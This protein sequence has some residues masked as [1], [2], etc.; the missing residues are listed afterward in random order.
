M[1]LGNVAAK[2]DNARGVMQEVDKLLDFYLGLSQPGHISKA[3]LSK[4]IWTEVL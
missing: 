2:S 4:A 1:Y 3:G